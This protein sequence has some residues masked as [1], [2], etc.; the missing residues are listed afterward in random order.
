MKVFGD[1]IMLQVC[2]FFHIFN[3]L[4]VDR[5]FAIGYFPIGLIGLYIL[6]CILIII[7][8]TII[9]LR[10]RIRIYYSKRQFFKK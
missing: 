6:F 5:N 7:V 1:F 3:M 2:Y 9:N 4:D 10:L 8:G